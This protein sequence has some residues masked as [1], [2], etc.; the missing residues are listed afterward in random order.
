MNTRRSF[1]NISYY[2][3]AIG[4]NNLLFMVGVSVIR[5]IYNLNVIA[6][7]NLFR[8]LSFEPYIKLLVDIILFAIFMLKSFIKSGKRDRMLMLV[9]GF[10][11]IPIQIVYFISSNYYTTLIST[12]TEFAGTAPYV[13]FYT[14]THVLKYSMIFYVTI[15]AL[16]VTGLSL[17]DYCLPIVSMILCILYTASFSIREMPAITIPGLTTIGIVIPSFLY[18]IT[19]SAIMIASGIYLI[20]RFSI[21]RKKNAYTI[22]NAIA[23]VNK[24]TFLN[25]LFKR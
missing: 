17:G 3:I 14:S 16:F 7:A 4:V 5:Y 22:D 13:A 20:I 2:L 6:Y 21:R 8:F 23:E 11:M 24:K 19:E 12:M 18:H 25:K 9:W 1:G 15:F 10:V